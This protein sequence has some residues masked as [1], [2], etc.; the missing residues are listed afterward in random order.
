MRPRAMPSLE[1]SPITIPSDVPSPDRLPL[2]ETPRHEKDDTQDQYGDHASGQ[3]TAAA[4]SHEIHHVGSRKWLILRP[5]RIASIP[6]S[7]RPRTHGGAAI[8]SI[9]RYAP[10]HRFLDLGELRSIGTRCWYVRG[11]R[12]P[13]PCEPR[14]PKY[15]VTSQKPWGVPLTAPGLLL[16]CGGRSSS[17]LIVPS[18]P[19]P[20]RLPPLSSAPAFSSALQIAASFS[21]SF[22]LEDS[23][24][25]DYPAE[26]WDSAAH[27]CRRRNQVDPKN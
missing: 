19:L 12:S 9:P 2:V 27:D 4:T 20:Y 26:K 17:P 18:Q 25:R 1:K 21:A 14:V 22:L 15:R 8:V 24:S 6:S 10:T 3:K 16:N 23:S 11:A 7:N 13:S 5:K